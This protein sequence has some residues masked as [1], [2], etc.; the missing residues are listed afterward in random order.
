MRRPFPNRAWSWTALLSLA[1]VAPSAPAWAEETPGAV[2]LQPHD[3]TSWSRHGGGA[4]IIEYTLPKSG[5]VRVR[6]FDA[7]GREIACPVNEWQT[8][9]THMTTF[10]FGP[11]TK[12]QVFRYRVECGR[13][14]RTGKITIEP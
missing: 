9:G 1:C 5:R 11:S 6:V 4:S 14:T 7:G 13:R 10:A 2:K 8:A 3:T 12:T